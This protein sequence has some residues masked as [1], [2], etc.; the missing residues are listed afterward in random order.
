MDFKFCKNCG[1][2][3]YKTKKQ[4]PE[5]FLLRNFCDYSCEKHFYSDDNWYKYKIKKLEIER[6]DVGKLYKLRLIVLERDHYKCMLCGSNKK[7]EMHHIDPVST[8]PE[9]AYE[10]LNCITLC[11]K[12]H[13]NFHMKQGGTRN[14]Y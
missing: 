2:K 4:P 13:W 3:F 11:E 5:K 1:K 6:R 7:L 9:K 14:A 12:C 10:E 8:Y